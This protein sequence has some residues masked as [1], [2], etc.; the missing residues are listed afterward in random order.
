M[1]NETTQYGLLGGLLGP[2]EDERKQARN[3]G[4]LQAGLAMLAHP[5]ARGY[6]PSFGE[7]AGQGGLL[8]LQ[9][10]QNALTT[11]PRSALTR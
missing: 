7:V 10:Y 11:L 9:S 4:L 8:G 3:M 6:R 5:G 2:T 1:A